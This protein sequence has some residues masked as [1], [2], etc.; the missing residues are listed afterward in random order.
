MDSLVETAQ[1]LQLPSRRRSDLRVE[2]FFDIYLTSYAILSNYCLISLE[3]YK[4][5]LFFIV[6]FGAS[7]FDASPMFFLLSCLSIKAL[8]YGLFDFERAFGFSSMIEI[9]LLS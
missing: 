3:R 2:S 1:L 5:H 9:N 8:I 6:Y 7:I 4:N